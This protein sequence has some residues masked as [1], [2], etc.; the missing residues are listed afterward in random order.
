M[1][2]VDTLERQSGC[3]GPYVLEYYINGANDGGTED[4]SLALVRVEE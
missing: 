1:R 2:E 3:G 4:I